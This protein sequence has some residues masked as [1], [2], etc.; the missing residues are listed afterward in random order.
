VIVCG[1]EVIAEHA[2]S[3]EHEAMV[4]DPLHYLALL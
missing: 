3:Y 4:Y 2:R 1:S